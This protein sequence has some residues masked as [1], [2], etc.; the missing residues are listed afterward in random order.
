VGRKHER[1][2]KRRA[3]FTAINLVWHQSLSRVNVSGAGLFMTNRNGN[4]HHNGIQ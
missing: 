3:G 2:A 1:A 4:L